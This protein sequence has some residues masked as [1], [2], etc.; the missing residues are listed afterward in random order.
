MIL[1][2]VCEKLP[3]YTLSSNDQANRRGA[4]QRVRLS[5]GLGA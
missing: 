5:A 3:K 4:K 2:N 1:S